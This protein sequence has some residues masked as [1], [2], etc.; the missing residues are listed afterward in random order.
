LAEKRKRMERGTPQ[1]IDRQ[2]IPTNAHK[3]KFAATGEHSPLG[4]KMEK[5][6][7]S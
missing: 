5:E 7:S 6:G 4:G 2:T 1:T 3:R